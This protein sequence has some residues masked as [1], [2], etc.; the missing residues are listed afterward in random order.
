V[1][2]ARFVFLLLA[3][4]VLLLVLLPG[5]ARA[6]GWWLRVRS[7]GDHRRF[8]VHDALR[9]SYL[10][11]VPPADLGTLPV[12]APK[13][14]GVPHLPLLIVLHGGGGTGA[15]IARLTGFSPL[16]DR[17][18]FVVAYPDGVNNHWNDGRNV[19]RFRAQRENVDDVG[20]I[21]RLIDQLAQRLNLDRT[22]VYI[23]GM[24]NGAMMCYRLGCDRAEKIAAIAPVCG[25]LA[26]DLPDS[27]QSELPM[28]VLAING[29]KDPLVPW[30]GGGVGL[31]AKR[32]R[33]RSVPQTIEYWVKRNDCSPTPVVAELPDR[34]PNDGISV[35]RE[36]YGQGQNG[37]EVILYVVTGGGH[38]WPGGQE[39]A[40][41]FGK[42][43]TDFNA[44]E[45]IW[46]FCQR[47]SRPE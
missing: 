45:T 17:E 1:T 33:V 24:S 35:R 14:G 12:F 27:A 9:R 16:A 25:A 41:R 26:E 34:D 36:V 10:L 28:S 46:Q 32:G 15:G 3:L 13:T 22:R 8:L 6:Q 5:I 44:T 11:H 38:T 19:Q 20:F 4:L 37:S 40:L 18:G 42:R 31:L 2:I 29:T 7:P 21:T 43:S 30:G 47:H 39:R 23:T